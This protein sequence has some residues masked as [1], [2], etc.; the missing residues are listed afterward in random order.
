MMTPSTGRNGGSMRIAIIGAGNVGGGLGAALARVGH[1]V[2]FGV[3]DPDSDKTRQAL[4][5]APS[6][7]ASTPAEAV[8]GAEVVIFTLRWDAV[9]DTVAA[10]PP[11][12]G[13]VVI[14]AMNRFGGDAAR[15]T[16]QDLAELLSGARVVKCFNTIGYENL[17]TAGSRA[18]PAA[19]FVAGDDAEAK[20][21]AMQLATEI[22]FQ[23]EDAG[24][25]ANAKSLE[26]MV[27]V[28]L[29]LSQKHGRT[30]GFAISRG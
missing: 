15:S 16:S 30:V 13:R 26:E 18:T 3:R 29:A 28:W 12:D 11:L 5:A 19:M 1:E 22:G 27:K 6:A 24:A 25:L 2:I 9:P 17:T 23:A 10:L 21:T 7:R 20:A 14:D 8:D 4:A